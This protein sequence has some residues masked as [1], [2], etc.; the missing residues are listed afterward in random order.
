MGLIGIICWIVAL[1]LF[2]S[3]AIVPGIGM[4]LIGW[5]LIGISG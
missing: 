5:F 3:G 2:F 4:L 1:W